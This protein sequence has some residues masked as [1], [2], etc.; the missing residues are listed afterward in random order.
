MKPVT[1]IIIGA[2]ERGN[3]Y[4]SYSLLH[5]EELKITGVAEP[6]DYYRK[7]FADKFGLKNS[8]KTWE[9]A[10]SKP[11]IA[12]AAIIA[13]QDALHAE[14][15]IEFAGK[16][17]HILLEKPMA[18][19]PEDCRRIVKAVRQSNILFSVCHVLR[20]THYTKKIK[21]MVESGKIGEVV[22]IQRLEPVGFWH[23]AHSFVRGN[24]R[25]ADESSFMLLAKSCHDIDWLHY[26]MGEKCRAASS[27]G[28][29]FHF[30]SSNKPEGAAARC[31]DCPV[32][33]KCPYSAKRIYL[34]NIKKGYAGW[35]VSVI[36][37][38]LTEEGVIKALREGPYGRCVYSCDNDVVDNQVV[39]MVFEKGQT[40][41][42]TMTAFTEFALRKT[43]I[44]GTEGR[45]EGDGQVI[46]H[47]DFLT[48]KTSRIN[49]NLEENGGLQGH[50]GGDY[51]IMKHF[52]KALRKKDKKYILSGVDETLE[53][54][55]I[56][57]NAEKSRCE[58]RVVFMEQLK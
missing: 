39:N 29:L 2:G 5:P 41:S 4:A 16:G 51:Q 9:E 10:A 50:G 36:T 45:L 24:W 21:A 31:L 25:R 27:F 12:D 18:P 26:I 33:N 48:D 17:Y 58:N 44:F 23:Y 40:A 7:S 53:S 15:A 37:T 34:S 43:I 30:K 20:Y 47:Y 32:E 42:F 11:Q 14:P 8:F 55:L 57:F 1:A 49:V 35:P 56:V 52:V 38:D 3:I 28:S 22:S 54:H 6:R 46:N 19:N 13:T